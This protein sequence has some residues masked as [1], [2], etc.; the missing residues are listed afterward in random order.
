MEERHA[1]K[2]LV[3]ALSSLG[4]KNLK[5]FRCKVL[6]QSKNKGFL[7]VPKAWMEG[8]T[9]LQF[10]KVMFSFYGQGAALEM[11]REALK[12]MESQSLAERLSLSS[13]TGK[14]HLSQERWIA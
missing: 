11:V 12:T 6:Q 3:D 2:H 5:R 13:R 10:I 4:E 7:P 14:K 1:W 8:T 9:L